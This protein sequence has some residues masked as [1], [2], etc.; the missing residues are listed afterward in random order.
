MQHIHTIA[1]TTRSADIAAA[2]SIGAAA[3]VNLA[4]INLYVQI[5]AGCVAI[6]AGLSA[7]VFHAFKTYELYK[8]RKNETKEG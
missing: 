2:G 3:A 8:A 5:A 7:A 4:N 6:I 1:Q